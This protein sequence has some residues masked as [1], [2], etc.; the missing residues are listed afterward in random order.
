[1]EINKSGATLTNDRITGIGTL[2]YGG[3][4]TLTATGDP[5][6]AG[7][8]FTLFDATNYLSAFTAFNLPALGAG[9]NWDSTQLSANGTITVLASGSP[10][11]AVATQ[12]STQT[13]DVGTSVTLLGGA[14]GTLPITYQWRFNGSDI[15]GQTGSSLTFSSVQESNQ[16]TYLFVASNSAGSVTS[17]PAILTVNQAPLAQAQSLSLPWNNSVNITL[18]GSD[19]DGDAF[20]FTITVQPAHGTLTGTAPNLTYTPMTSYVGPDSFTYRVS[21]GRL[22]ATATISLTVVAGFTYRDT[23]LLLVYRKDGANDYLINLGNVSNYINQASGTVVPISSFNLAAVQANFGG[24]LSGVKSALIAVTPL[25]NLPLRAWVSDADRSG[26]PRD[27]PGS[28]WSQLRGKINAIGVSATTYLTSSNQTL[29]LSS[30]DVGSYTS[31]ASEGGLLDVST[32]GGT[33]PFPVEQDV[34]GHL[35]LIELRVSNANP[36]PFSTQVGS[37]DLAAD[38]SLVFTAGLTAPAIASQPS[39]QSAECGASAT[40]SV[41]ATGDGPLSYQWYFGAAPIGGATASTFTRGVVGFA[42]AGSYLVVV[43]NA[44]GSTTSSVATLTVTDTTPPVL[45]LPSNITVTRTGAGGATVNYSASATDACVGS[46]GVSCSPISG[47]TFAVGVTTV[48]CSA[49]DGNGNTANGSFTVTVQLGFTYQDTDLLLVYRKDGAN[50]YLINLGN[51]SNYINQASGTAI[52][53]SSFNLAAVQA[54]F[55]GS[56]SGVKSALIAVT[57]L[58]NLPLRAWL[59]DADG[60]GAPR[61]VPGSRWSQLRG[62]IN[63]IGVSATT[64]FTSSNQTLVLSS[65]DVGSY[66]SIASE[67]GLL[68]VSTLGGTSPFP[69]EQ[70]VPGHLRLIEVRVSNANPKPF[71]TQVGSFDL[72]ADGS[73]VFTAGVTRPAIASQPSSQSAECGASATFSVSGTGDG[74]L[75]YQWYFGAAPIG[76]AT[77]STYT[78]TGLTLADAGNYS[79]VVANAGGSITSSVVTLTVTDTAPISLAIAKAGTNVVVSWPQTCSTYT[80]EQTAVLTMPSSGWSVVGGAVAAGGQ[81]HVVLVPSATNAFFRLRRP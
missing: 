41:S 24:S 70:D 77:A 40:F 11:L 78:R 31:I 15:S 28:R 13:A 23:D 67:G 4:L 75:S 5:L 74:P 21:D 45:S 20:T 54:N 42:D 43:A 27:I 56:L 52:P 48:N 58:D 73:L 46:V 37:F 49:N 26:A 47:S 79:V 71:S 60:S 3:T 66:T 2:T 63:A 61:D 14:I 76:G 39:S 6:A 16:G 8:A 69:V 62:K 9:L 18:A 50:D 25:D 35:R 33:S 32:L 19:P 22:T 38:G 17:A 10:T 30:S 36:K 1:M 29:V 72:A 81:W 34:P 12:P 7:D 44:G 59:S 80:L 51:V 55:G 65:S 53:I 57:P 64:Y 68:D